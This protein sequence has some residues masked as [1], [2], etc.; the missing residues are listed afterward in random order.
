MGFCKEITQTYG[1]QHILNFWLVSLV[2]SSNILAA[3][4]E[5]VLLTASLSEAGIGK[6]QLAWLFSAAEQ[7][8]RN[9]QSR[10]ANEG[11]N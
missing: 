6:V 10:W 4:I 3:P 11:T 9:P 2:W 1:W 8:K 7:R 5:L